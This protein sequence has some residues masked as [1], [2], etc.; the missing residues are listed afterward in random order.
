M[1]EYLYY[2]CPTVKLNSSLILKSTCT[3][4]HTKY[5]KIDYKN[6]EPIVWITDVIIA[7][8]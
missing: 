3:H 2:H 6:F 8:Y 4:S 7:K 5:K 1:N